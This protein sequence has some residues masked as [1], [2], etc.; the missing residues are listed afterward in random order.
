ME[1]YPDVYGGILKMVNDEW[2][3][4]DVRYLEEES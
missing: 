2:D 1:E 4:K 3:D